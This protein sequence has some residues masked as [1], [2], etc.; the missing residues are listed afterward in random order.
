[1]RHNACPKTLAFLPGLGQPSAIIFDRQREQ[2]VSLRQVDPDAPGLAMT[3]GVADGL[4][5]NAINVRGHGGI[6]YQHG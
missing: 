1:M 4:L 6:V 5:R 3:D 2:T